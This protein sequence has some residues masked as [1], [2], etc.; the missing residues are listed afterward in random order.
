MGTASIGENRFF[1]D[2]RLRAIFSDRNNRNDAA[3]EDGDMQTT[4]F[5]YHQYEKRILT[6]Y[7]S[8]ATSAT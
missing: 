6:L 4:R 3:I 2:I 5:L 8:H 1:H 7:N